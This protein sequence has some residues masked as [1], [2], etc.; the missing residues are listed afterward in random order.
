MGESLREKTRV[1]VFPCGSEI[2]LEIHRAL[3]FSAHV[4]LVGASSVAS[5]HGPLVFREY[6]GGLP[7]VD[8]PDFVEALNRIVLDRRIDLLFP[9]H[10]S[11]VLRLAESEGKLACPVIGSPLET[12]A[13]CRSKRAAYKRLSG[14]VR[15]PR[16]W[17]QNE[18]DLPYPVFV[19][20]DAGQGAQGAMR[21][22]SRAALDAAL[23]RDPSLIILEYLPGAEYTVDCFT[24]RHGALRFAGARER[25]RTQGGISVDT[26]PV[27]DPIFREWAERIHGALSFR[28]PW[29]FQAKRDAAGEL[30]LLEAAPRVSGGMGLYR[31]LGVNLPLL[32]VYDRL[33]LDVEIACN[34]FPIEMDRALCNRFLAP[35][36]Y[37]DVY[38]DLDDTLIIDGEVN[39][40][41]A[42]FIFQC[43]NRGIRVHLVSRHAGDLGATLGQYRLAGLFDSIVPVGALADKS[44]HIAEKKA[45][46]IDDSF[47]ER[48]RVQ[49]ALGIPVFAPDAIE[50]L[51]DWRR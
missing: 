29:F 48:K 35:I 40:L 47:A 28:G 14:V 33:D 19:K 22:E 41:L 20:P 31:N 2:G 9:A 36:E 46:F 6:V 42:A 8:A 15:V 25:L 44:A 21:I 39:A 49:E 45:I 24:D 38:I 23:G 17:E 26:R 11:V 10:D 7:F 12:C 18:R 37:D 27:S 4:S 50:C 16:L 3:C 34:T 51:L 5:S 32:A 43:R 1:L 30:A 13:V